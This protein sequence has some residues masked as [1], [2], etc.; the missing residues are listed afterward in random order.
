M[1]NDGV[2]LDMHLSVI[3]YY[4]IFNNALSFRSSSVSENAGIHHYFGTF[5]GTLIKYL[6]KKIQ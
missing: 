6:A 3:E 1:E 5:N 4:F 2:E